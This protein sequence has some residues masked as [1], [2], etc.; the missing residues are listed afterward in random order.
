MIGY[1]KKVRVAAVIVDCSQVDIA[2]VC[3]QLGQQNREDEGLQTLE[4]LQGTAPALS[5]CMPRALLVF[6]V[7]LGVQRTDI[8]GANKS[9][10]PNQS[11]PTNPS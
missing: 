9:A 7:H 6:C 3:V 4:R 5:A 10:F 8:N 2:T 11:C 1:E